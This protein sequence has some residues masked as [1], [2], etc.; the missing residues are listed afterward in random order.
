MSG[1]VMALTPGLQGGD[2]SIAVSRVPI[3]FRVNTASFAIS[4]LAEVPQFGGTVGDRHLG[5]RHHP[6][7]D[8][9]HAGDQH[10]VGRHQHRPA[11]RLGADRTDAAC[12]ARPPGRG[13]V[14]EQGG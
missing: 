11:A 6:R 14:G 4:V 9:Q 2:G 7:A 12:F 8:R 1:N 13:F 3:N 10:V 5:R